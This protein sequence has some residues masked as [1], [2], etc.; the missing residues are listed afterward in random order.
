MECQKVKTLLYGYVCEA[1]SPRLQQKVLMHLNTGCESCNKS[2]EE[3]QKRLGH[4]Q[5]KI[6]IP[7]P[8]ISPKTI[9]KTARRKAIFH[10]YLTMIIML[11]CFIIMLSIGLYVNRYKYERNL[12]IELTKAIEVYQN[13]TGSYPKDAKNLYQ[14][15]YKIKETHVY[16]QK[17]QQRLNKA[18]EL[19]DGWGT[20]IIYIYPGKKNKGLFDI[21]SFGVNKKDNNGLWDDIRN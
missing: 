3:V 13:M 12:L 8:S 19:T 6:N 17:W 20:P 14:K 2:L 9:L 7:I 10:R 1:L 16:L 21:Y 15:L 4:L 5:A 18:N 11:I